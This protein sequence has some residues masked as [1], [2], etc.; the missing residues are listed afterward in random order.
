MA[1]C[2]T[3]CGFD[4]LVDGAARRF[5]V[6]GHRISVVR[7]GERVFAIGDRCSHANFSLAEGY[8]SV[9]GCSLECPKHGSSFSLTTGQPDSLPAIKPVPVYDVSVE[10]DDVVVV[11]PGGEG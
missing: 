8:L 6:D 7:V 3:I 1:E 10:G 9:D 4:E 11:L 5:D 2:H